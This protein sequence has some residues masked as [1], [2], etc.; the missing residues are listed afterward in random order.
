MTKLKSNIKYLI[1]SVLSY[2]SI[3]AYLHMYYH[4]ILEYILIP[5]I[6][7]LLFIYYKKFSD[8]IKLDKIYQVFIFIM[9]FILVLGYSYEIESTASLFFG[10]IPVFIISILKVLGYYIFFK[11]LVNLILNFMH[12]PIYQEFKIVK[13]FSN[14]PFL[15][16]F[17]LL[18][19][20]YGIFLISYYPGVINYDNANQIKE[21][22]GLHT[23]YLDAINPISDSTLTNFNPILHTVLLGGLFKIGYLIGNVNFG[24]FLYTL[25]QLIIVISIYSYAI[26]Y[27]FKNTKSKIIPIII[28]LIACITPTLGYYSITAVKDTLYTAFLLL[29]TIRIY[30]YIKSDYITKK[31][32]VILFL[33]SM[34]VILFR[35]NGIYIVLLT[36]PFLLY[37]N[38]L[39]IIILTVLVFVSNYSFNN[40]LLPTLGVSGTSIREMLSIPFQ[41]TARLAEINPDAF[42]KEQ[43][44]IIGNVLDYDNL[45]YD[46]NEDLSD[47]VK[48]K[49]NKDATNEDLIKYFGVWFD[50]LIHH[51]F[52]YIDAT[53]NNIT[54]YFYPFESSWKVYHKLNP[55]LPEAGFDYHYNSLSS[56]RNA[57]HDYEVIF[58]YSPLGI[59]LNMGV[60]TYLS[61][62]AF[63]MLINKNKYYIFLIPNIISILFCVLSPANTYYR[64]IYPSLVIMLFT[65]PL[66]KYQLELTKQKVK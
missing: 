31:D 54:S 23:R 52:I 64:Y 46:Y 27:T 12:K 8:H 57:M 55:K 24:L 32:Y 21:M 60:I 40:I 30:D 49:Y 50:G 14:H 42:T 37:K 45:A 9:S 35:N 2:L 47:P 6:I 51:P 16:S 66:I 41:Q 53:I 15:Y 48:N 65:F 17:I 26:S 20:F 61:I 3:M 18:S 19:I 33:V 10:S 11:V 62:L 58:E 13:K 44:V 5:I 1:Y 38:K 7:S 63:L 34:L 29:F 28:L 22:L 43:Q 4:P 39:P 56:M 59:I 36:L 25:L